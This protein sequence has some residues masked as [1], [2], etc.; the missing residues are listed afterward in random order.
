MGTNNKILKTDKKMKVFATLFILWLIVFHHCGVKNYLYATFLH[1]VFT[2]LKI[3]TY[4]MFLYISFS[5]CSINHRLKSK[6]QTHKTLTICKCTKNISFCFWVWF[7]KINSID[8]LS[9]YDK[10]IHPDIM[11]LSFLFLK[12]HM[13]EFLNQ[14]K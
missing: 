5:F 14:R 6:Q 12:W 9:I 8:I 13:T 10:Y 1:F 7:H 11:S 2:M 4:S 3:I